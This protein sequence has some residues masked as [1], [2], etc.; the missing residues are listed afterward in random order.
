MKALSLKEP[1]ASAVV[2][3]KKSIET[4][5]WNTRFRGPFLIHASKT[6]DEYA[7]GFLKTLYSKDKCK[8]GYIIGKATL[9]DVYKYSSLREFEQDSHFHLCVWTEEELKGTILE[10]ADYGY[11]LV[12]AKRTDPIKEVGSLGF[13]DYRVKF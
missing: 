13:W 2:D 1:W 3:S 10:F 4:R 8:L 6:Y 12:D 5:N 11:V 9:L 7:P